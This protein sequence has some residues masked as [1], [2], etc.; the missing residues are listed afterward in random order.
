MTNISQYSL[1]RGRDDEMSIDDATSK[2]THLVTPLN[3]RIL[4]SDDFLC[5]DTDYH[6]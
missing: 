5:S 2:M 4:Y 3:L 6:K 1:S